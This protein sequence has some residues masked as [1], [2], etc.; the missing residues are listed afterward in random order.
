[1]WELAMLLASASDP[2]LGKP[3]EAIRLAER[4]VALTNRQSVAALEA[5]AAAYAAAG[6]FDE[7]VGTQQQAIDLAVANRVPSTEPLRSRLELY[8]RRKPLR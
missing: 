7:A 1:M 2:E 6:R 4:A 3:D 5:A 8:R